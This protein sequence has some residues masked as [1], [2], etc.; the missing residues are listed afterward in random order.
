MRYL[1]PLIVLFL[2]AC[3]D[4]KVDTDLIQIPASGQNKGQVEAFNRDVAQLTPEEQVFNYDTVVEGAVIVHTFTFTNTGTADLL[5]ADVSSGCGCTVPQQ[6]TR[7][8]IPPGDGGSI[9]VTFD[10][11]GWS[12]NVDKRITAVTNG[13]PSVVRFVLNGHILSPNSN[14]D[15]AVLPMI[16]H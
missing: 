5:L 2:I 13:E 12:G 15:P 7:D 9:D 16:R 11:R 14:E 1:S 3:D 8:L 4:P 10:T 6:W